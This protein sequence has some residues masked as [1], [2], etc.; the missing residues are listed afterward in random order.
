MEVTEN[1]PSNNNSH[2]IA[3]AMILIRNIEY[4]STPE[5]MCNQVQGKLVT[6]TILFL[7]FLIFILLLANPSMDHESS[8]SSSNLLPIDN[9]ITNSSSHQNLTY[10][11]ILDDLEIS[12]SDEETANKSAQI[13]SL[14]KKTE[15]ETV[16][17]LWF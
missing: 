8:T 10:L 15:N 9:F 12:D 16:G 1:N 3:K 11:S 5:T 13:N 2:Q 4:N 6:N 14:D 17:E 7:Q